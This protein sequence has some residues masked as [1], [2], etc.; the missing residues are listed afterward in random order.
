MP[1]VTRQ[2]NNQQEESKQIVIPVRHTIFVLEND[3]S[4]NNVDNTEKKD[5]GN[6]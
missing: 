5:D 3:P 1:K 4:K 2:I 6:E